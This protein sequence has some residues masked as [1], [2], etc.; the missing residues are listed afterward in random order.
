[1]IN[2]GLLWTPFER[3]EPFK[4]YRKAKKAIDL[5][6]VLLFIMNYQ[7]MTKKNNQLICHSANN[8]IFWQKKKEKIMGP[9]WLDR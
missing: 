7:K 2:F 4:P 1:M 9:P 6:L 3:Q 8:V 5:N